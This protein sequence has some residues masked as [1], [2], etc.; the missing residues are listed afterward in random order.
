MLRFQNIVAAV[1]LTD[2]SHD[3][4]E[5]ALQLAGAQH[6]RVHL[7]H[8]VP[9]AL[10]SAWLLDAAGPDLPEV[11]RRWTDDSAQRL[12]AFAA[13][14]DVDPLN[15][16]T[17]VLVGTPSSQIVNYAHEHTADAIVLGSHGHGVIGRFVLGSVAE[18]VMRQAG[19]PVMIVPHL[20]RGVTSLETETVCD[21]G[22]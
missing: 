16:P 21:A 11:Q 22:A 12:I 5:A 7:I 6:A 20:P 10:H 19:C 17:A 4:F 15:V 9:D 1:D 13:G 8:V 18:R 3:V 14:H 2:A